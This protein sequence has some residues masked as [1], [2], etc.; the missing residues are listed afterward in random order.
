MTRYL[1]VLLA[2]VVGCR[3]QSPAGS[4]LQVAVTFPSSLHADPITGRM[5]VLIAH[6]SGTEPRIVAGGFSI[7]V[8][9]YGVDVNG[10]RPGEAAVISDTTPGYPLASLKDIAPGDY[11]IQAVLNVY[12]QFKRS[13]GH[14]IWAHMDQWEGQQYT[15]SPG[16]LVS[17]V[18]KVHL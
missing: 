1:L 14:T 10:L 4:A 15:S 5:F 17:E 9:M 12:T 8:T 16:N 2:V 11:W 13:D 3:V 7:D 6:D 18:R